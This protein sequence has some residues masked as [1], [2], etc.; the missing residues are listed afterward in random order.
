MIKYWA[1]DEIKY[2]EMD[3]HKTVQ[4]AYH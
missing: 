4:W 1:I 2:Y 3:C